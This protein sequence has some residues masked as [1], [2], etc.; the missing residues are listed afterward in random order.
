M[1]VPDQNAL[2]CGNAAMMESVNHT[3]NHKH[4]SYSK[5]NWSWMIWKSRHK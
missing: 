2:Q 5:S 1:P 4:Y 3:Q